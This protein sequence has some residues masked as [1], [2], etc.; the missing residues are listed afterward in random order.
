MS[1]E[2]EIHQERI[3]GVDIEAVDNKSTRKNIKDFK[4]WLKNLLTRYELELLEDC[5]K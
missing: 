4:V 1:R 2:A 5:K 3:S